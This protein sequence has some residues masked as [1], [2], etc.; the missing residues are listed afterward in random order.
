MTFNPFGGKT[1]NLASSI[2]STDTTI[3][4][5]SFLEPVTDTPYTMALLN[6]DIAFG[7]IAPRTS[8]SEFISF[9]G[10]TQNSDGTATLTGVTRGLAKKYPF[11]SS[12]S[13]KLPHSGQSQF[14]ISDAPQLFNEYAA[15]GNDNVFTG[16]NTAPNPQSAQSIVTRDWILALI[17]GGS[18]TNNGIVETAIAGETV[19][20]GNLLYFSETDNEWL[21][22]DADTLATIFNV[23]LG[24]AQGAG[25]NGNAITGGVLTRGSY[26]T[27]GLTQGDL[28]YASNTAGAWNSGTSGTVPRVIGIAKDSTTLYFDPDFQNKLY[29]YAVDAVG[30]DAY[31]ITLSGALSIPFVGM[32]VNFVAGTANTGAATLAINGGSA[33]AI[34]KNATEDLVTGDVVANQVLK[35]V[36]NGTNWQL[37]SKTPIITPIVRTYLNGVSPAT[38]TKPAGLKYVI[39]EVQAAGGNGAAGVDNGASGTPGASGGGGG[40]S[41][42]L[43]AAATLGST[44]TVTIGTIA[45]T[46]SFGSHL[47]ATGGASASGATRGLGGIGSNGDINARG[48]DGTNTDSGVAVN[49]SGPVGGG[50]VLGSNGG[51][52]SSSSA[53]SVATDGGLYGGG[54]GGGMGNASV[55]TAGGAGGAGI[56]IVTEYY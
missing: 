25:T 2:G 53:G 12:S 31:A 41:R 27:S 11:T 39:V 44:E 14:I 33:I 47:S 42:K 55:G 18:I 8:S 51:G 26:T 15:L 22:T 9:T 49:G 32:E 46:S 43:I 30:T 38:W 6:T 13:Y 36:Y 29:N 20:A 4:L 37:I 16:D 50:S 34:K 21:K 19:A 52:G 28:V 45:A 40:Y 1:Y 54:G 10:I 17:N 5:S 56:V 3:L 48:G 23:K 24:I 35:V 7:T